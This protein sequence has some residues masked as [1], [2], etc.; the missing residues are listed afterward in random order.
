MKIK[1]KSTFRDYYDSW[2]D[3]E[4][5]MTWYRNSTGGMSRPEMLTYMEKLGLEVPQ[6]NY[7]KNI[8]GRVAPTGVH[9]ERVVVYLDNHSHRG[10]NKVVMTKRQA[11]EEHPDCYVADYVNYAVPI[12]CKVNPEHGRHRS[13]SLRYLQIGT[14]KFWLEYWSDTDWRSN[15]GEGGVEVIC[16]EAPGY[17]PK[18]TW[19]LFAIDFV[20]TRYRWQ[21]PL[22]VDF[23]IA[24]G[25]RGT[26]IE[27]I[28]RGPEAADLIKQGIVHYYS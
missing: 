15:C 10:E 27:D 24:P 12:M 7:L 22:A 14:R 9:S 11:L 19:P 6:H 5:P 2:F 28:I 20:V 1:L 21:Q 16:E 25:L 4:G 23:N 18:I 17:H 26:G 3:L 13:Q 8:Y